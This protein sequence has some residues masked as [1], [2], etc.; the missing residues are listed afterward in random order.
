MKNS[1]RKDKSVVKL[2]GPA[3]KGNAKGNTVAVILSDLHHLYKV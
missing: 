3:I 2:P 1:A